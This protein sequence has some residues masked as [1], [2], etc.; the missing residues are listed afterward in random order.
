MDG[1]DVSLPAAPM[2]IG[3][4]IQRMREEGVQTQVHC[5]VRWTVSRLDNGGVLA[6]HERAVFI[7]RSDDGSAARV[8]PPGMP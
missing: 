4:E 5:V 6:T 3:V 1:D 2:M 7:S 8:P